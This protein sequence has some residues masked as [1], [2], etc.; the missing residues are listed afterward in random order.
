MQPLRGGRALGLDV[1]EFERIDQPD[2]GARLAVAFRAAPDRVRQALAAV[3]AQPGLRA[4]TEVGE[5]ED[6]VGGLRCHLRGSGAG[7]GSIAGS[8]SFRG[9]EPLPAMR[10]C[11]APASTRIVRSASRPA[12]ARPAIAS[13][14]SLRASIT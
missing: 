12:P 13:R 9:V 6:G 8:L 1:K 10:V 3:P 4:G 2:G 14:T 5:R 11:A 7:T